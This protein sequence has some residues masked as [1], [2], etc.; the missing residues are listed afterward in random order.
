MANKKI[1]LCLIGPDSIHLDRWANW[2]L[3]LH[4]YNVTLLRYPR[5]ENIFQYSFS[6]LKTLFKYLKVRKNIDITH[7]HYVGNFAF[8][9]A[10]FVKKT[11]I[12]SAWGSDVLVAPKRFL[13]HFFLK[14][15]LKK[16]KFITC[17]GLNSKEAI[18]KYVGSS[19]NI[20]VIYHGVDTS[21]FNP[22]KRNLNLKTKIGFNKND[23]VVISTRAFYPIYDIDTF[24]KA[25][26]LV[27]KEKSQTKFILVGDGPEKDRLIN[28]VKRLKISKSVYFTGKITP[29]L[30]SIYLALS[31][32]YVSTSISDGGV[33]V[34]NMEAMASGLPVI[35]SNVGDNEKW[36]KPG[37]N[38][39]LFEIKDFKKLAEEINIL[40]SKPK[41]R[42][43]MS[44]LNRKL[45]LEK[46]DYF[47]EM[48]KV[49]KLYRSI[50]NK[51]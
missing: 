28:L 50:I 32:I 4:D 41:L 42:Q 40:I 3:K 27:L 23:L 38:G 49:N 37:I 24:I 16:A 8:L 2:F 12:L 5:Y 44:K 43:K 39:F 1:N 22:I 13:S 7:I 6:L 30:M 17:D 46:Y 14:K 31:D 34:S 33:A 35:V 20:K 15:C 29:N 26:P 21:F 36:I 10:P 47:K 9:I 25:I 19:K 11:L 51:E 45:V 18:I 48:S